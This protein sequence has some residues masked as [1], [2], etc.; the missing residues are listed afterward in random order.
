MIHALRTKTSNFSLF[1]FLYFLIDPNFD[2]KYDVFLFHIQFELLR[3]QIDVISTFASL[4][5]HDFDR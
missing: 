1:F 3:F 5:D 4:D 2:M